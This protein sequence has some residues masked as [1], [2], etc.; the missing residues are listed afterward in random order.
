MGGID[1][2]L[3]DPFFDDFRRDPRA[4]AL[5]ARFGFPVGSP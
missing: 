3:V 4:P 1:E 5:L 2:L